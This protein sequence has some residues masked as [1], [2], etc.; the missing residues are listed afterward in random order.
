MQELQPGTLIIKKT[1]NFFTTYPA[2]AHKSCIFIGFIGVTH[3]GLYISGHVN[4][5]GRELYDTFL[6]L[7]R[8]LDEKI[9]EAALCVA[10]KTLFNFQQFI[11]SPFTF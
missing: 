7:Q 10:I 11:F 3:P 4:F 1:E 5:Y 6:S 2:I 9:S 8:L